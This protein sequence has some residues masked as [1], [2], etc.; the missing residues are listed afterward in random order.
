MKSL[1][2]NTFIEIY[3]NNNVYDF[4][5]QLVRSEISGNGFSVLVF[6]FDSSFIALYRSTPI[7]FSQY[8]ENSHRCDSLPVCDVLDEAV[9][10]LL[11]FQLVPIV[12]FIGIR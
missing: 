12:S 10:R 9:T 4:S 7:P 1:E 5:S 3:S 8:L 6:R 2:G 11:T